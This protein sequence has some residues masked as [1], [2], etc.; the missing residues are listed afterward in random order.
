MHVR[1]PPLTAFIVIFA[2]ALLVPTIAIFGYEDG[3]QYPYLEVDTDN[4][5]TTTFLF[6]QRNDEH[7]CRRVLHE[8]ARRIV[9]VCQSCE[10]IESKCL[11]S[12]NP[13]QRRLLSAEPL[14]SPSARLE[15]AIVVYKSLDSEAALAGCKESERLSS[16]TLRCYGP[17]EQRPLRNS[18]EPIR[19]TA[20]LASLWFGLVT[21][22]V[23]W[24]ACLFIVRFPS[25]QTAWSM[26][27]VASGPQKFHQTPTPR[28]GGLAIL[29]SLLLVG[30]VPLPFNSHRFSGEEYGYLMLAGLPA[31]VAGLSEDAT[32]RVPVMIRLFA[33]IVAAVFCAWLLSAVIRRLDIPLVDDAL[34]WTPLA[35]A[36]TA[37]AVGGVANAINII[38]GY[39]GLVGGYAILVL[40][41][42]AA[43]SAQ[44][45]DVFIF[46]SAI[47]MLG[48]L[49]GFMLWN[50]PKGTIFLG[51]GGAYFVGFWLAE[52]SVLLVSR[53]QTVSPWF[54]L[55]LLLY[56]V[57]ETV[58]SMY[59]KKVLRGK[60]PGQ[61]D[62]LH[63]H[64]LIY[65]RVLPLSYKENDSPAHRNSRVS[66]YVWKLAL[67]SIVPG[68]VFWNNTI[69]L[70]FFACTFC[71]FYVWFYRRIV[72]LDIPK[73]LSSKDI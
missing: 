24:I 61:P 59:R 52:L 48:A 5:I 71:V 44:V 23:S 73:W 60:S 64:M 69:P 8:M 72:R 46:C 50:F 4:K 39:N 25:P 54:P 16:S 9:S 2:V 29:V 30:I 31:F 34:A 26:D 27:D 63:L 32:K 45:G 51:D 62:G 35:L 10:V 41:A 3:A 70:A 66:P 65:K 67:C 33:T 19:L 20:V 58:F 17:A 28:I 49:A 12:L 36:F 7:S 6:E 56:P 11:G 21:L 43:I 40:I 57:F 15:N 13:E 22:M 38:D 14:D 1:R 37:I 53:N 47:A 18:P 68:A 55:L 42:M